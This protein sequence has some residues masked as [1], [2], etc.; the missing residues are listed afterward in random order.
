MRFPMLA[1]VAALIALASVGGCRASGEALVRDVG[2]AAAPSPSAAGGDGGGK[3]LPCDVEQ[4]LAARCVSCHGEDPVGPMS[5]LTHADLAARSISDPT[6]SVAAVALE[7]MRS[8]AR[9]MPPSAQLPEAD[10]A[11]LA[12]W[13]EAGTPRVACIPTTLNRPDG[14]APECS[15]ASD[16]P[17]D[18]VCRAGFCEVECV[19]D[20]DCFAGTVC[21]QT[22]CA[23]AP[24]TVVTPTY[25]PLNEPSSW[26]TADLTDFGKAT[27]GGATFDG[28]YVYFAPEGAS[29]L[30][31]RHD[32]RDVFGAARSW[33]SFDLRAAE[34]RAFGFRGAA[35][36]G[37]YV[38]YVP[39]TS[40]VMARFDTTGV[41]LGAAAWTF[42]D[43]HTV[44]AQASFAGAAFDGRYLFLAPAGESSIVMRHDTQLPFTDARAWSTFDLASVNAK[45]YGFAGA[46]FDGRHV[47]FVP[48][49]RADGPHALVVRYDSEA[50]FQKPT[51]YA[52]VDLASMPGKG[53]GF[54][55]G[56]FDGRFVYLVPGWGQAPEWSSR[57]VARFDTKAPFATSTSWSSIDL[58]PA[59]GVS[60]AFNA[61][62]F[63]GRHIVLLPGYD[64]VAGAYHGHVARYDTTGEMTSPSSWTKLALGSVSAPKNIRGAAFSGRYVYFAP[65]EGRAA[66]LEARKAGSPLDG[67]AVSFY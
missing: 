51:S 19:T 7:R 3:D 61:A 21:R 12:K 43:L 53:T 15:L 56:A 6:K 67:G 8:A 25:A 22:R 60:A 66:R 39:G 54:R 35:F 26:T 33:T 18:L 37:R 9:P 42:Y 36:D 58:G 11:T 2:D 62:V 46:V 55:T 32:T 44:S 45:A 1:L 59:A 41:F 29:G 65:N 20:K 31:L 24:P 40:G 4:L 14:S 49:A 38:Y 27:Y 17:G 30:A 52:A 48:A 34:S 10:I 57:T 23:S 63:D 28:R 47:Y 5:L 16:C 13:V 64:P 50:G